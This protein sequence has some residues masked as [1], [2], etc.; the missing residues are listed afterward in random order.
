LPVTSLTEH[1]AKLMVI[2]LGVLMILHG[3]GVSI[4]PILTALGVGGLAVALA[5][6]DTLSNLFAGLY[7]TMARQVRIG[8][9]IKLE[10]GEEGYIEDIGWRATMIRA[11]ANNIV[12]VPNNKLGSALITNFNLPSRDLAVLVN[13]GVDYGSDL[14]HVERVTIEVAKDVMQTVPG[15]VKEFEPFIRYHTFGAYSIDFTVI[16]RGKEFTDQ[17]LIKH[18]FVKRLHV[19][20]QQ[21]DITIPFPIQTEILHKGGQSKLDMV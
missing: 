13:L 4:T 12:M 14:A 11:L 18:E 15:G 3:L 8:D 20:Y 10:S 16:M 9:Y 1:V 19:R 5:L 6:Q 7:V 17:F 2:I 21:E